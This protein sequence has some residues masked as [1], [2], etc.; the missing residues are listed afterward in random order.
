MKTD[1]LHDVVCFMLNVHLWSGR[2][3]L[4]PEDLRNVRSDQ[5]PPHKLASLGSKK[6]CDP[7]RLNPFDKLKKRMERTLNAHGTRFL[8]G[9]AIPVKKAEK[10]GKELDGIVA[11]AKIEI[12]KFLADYEK[13]VEDWAQGNAEWAQIIRAAISPKTEVE[14]QLH[15]GYQ[16][17]Q[18]TPVTS[19]TVGLATD[20]N[21][22]V[23]SLGEQL[24]REIS[25][26]ATKA[27]ETSFKGKEK[28]SQKALRPIRAM[29]EK[30]EGLSF[31]DSRIDPLLLRIETCLNDLPK[32][33]PI[34]GKDFDSLAGLLL[35]LQDPSRVKEH[36][37]GLR[38]ASANVFKN[39]SPPE[40]KEGK[41]DFSEKEEVD[42][43]VEPVQQE[44]PSA[45]SSQESTP[46]W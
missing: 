18:I 8:G 41:G 1:V 15:F 24:F 12:A 13:A 9:W 25:S 29:M 11:E 43:E 26:Q 20:L 27:W 23:E 45:P 35:V 38:H 37:E 40:I 31:L 16:V 28:V 36:G 39:L 44:S 10:I 46:W 3:K 21:A 42:T 22:E 7:E 34:D 17:F 30:M 19:E 4:H 5:I 14:K 2:K 6:I 33:G 32:H